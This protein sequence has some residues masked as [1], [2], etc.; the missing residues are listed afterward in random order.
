[1]PHAAPRLIPI[2][3][4]AAER[5]ALGS[6]AVVQSN[7]D[8]GF[9]IRRVYFIYGMDQGAERGGHAHK[10][11]RQCLVMAHG[12]AR[13][14]LE[15]PA[16][17]HEFL[18]DSPEQGLIVPPEYWRE[19]RDFSKDAVLLALASDDYDPDDY[20]RDYGEFKRWSAER[21]TVFRVPY[22]DLT[23]R[24]DALRLDLE[25][26]AAAVMEECRYIMGP[27]LE[28]FEKDFA[29]FCGTEY[30][31]GTGNGLDALELILRGLGVGP[32][33]EVIM[34]AGGFI[35]TPLAVLAVGAKPVFA[36][37]LPF[38]NIDPARIEVVVTEN[39][40]AVLLTHLYGLPADMDAI[41]AVAERRGL[42]VIEDACQAHGSR[43][44][45]RA[46]GGLGHAAAFSFYPTKN[47]GGFGDGGCITTNDKALAETVRKLR[48]YGSCV[49]Y[50]NELAG[51][52]SRLDE[53]QAA[54]L[55]VMLPYV[56]DWNARR[57]DLAGI[58]FAELG[59][60]AGLVLPEFE[61]HVVP[62]WHVFPVRVKNGKRDVLA[63]FLRE[64]GIGSNIHYPLA[65]HRQ[66]CLCGLGFKPGDFPVAE[67]LASEELSLPLDAFTSED[68]V[69]YAAGVVREF[70]GGVGLS[71]SRDTA[72][73]ES[74]L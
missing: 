16:G 4:I 48:N 46:C 74:S 38:G 22:I 58:Y 69:R 47:L 56:E 19:M 71:A 65:M 54:L 11:M 7:V 27:R 13:I 2:R 1:M 61:G 41:C 73:Y 36:D 43:Y 15:G 64:R 8:L 26:A 24:R 30:C 23:R 66:E 34:S 10:E 40:R 3:N 14:A 33:D 62:N 49:K 5:D 45:G 25:Q 29:A 35:A 6:L 67:A 12:S 57:R 42:K 63:E 51:K 21:A 60:E 52:N 59:G 32:G 68:E 55:S 39:T 28:R 37:C 44:K 17:R 50:Y 9:P 72:R 70:F 20:I 31:V 18:L 53:M